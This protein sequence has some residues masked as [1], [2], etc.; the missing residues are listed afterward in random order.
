MPPNFARD[1][2]FREKYELDGM[3]MCSATIQRDICR[4]ELRRGMDW[5]RD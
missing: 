3:I 4:F 2:G 1:D 5:V